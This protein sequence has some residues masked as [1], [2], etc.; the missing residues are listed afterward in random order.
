MVWTLADLRNRPSVRSPTEG[1]P[2]GISQVPAHQVSGT[3]PDFCSHITLLRLAGHALQP[4]SFPPTPTIHQHHLY[5][6]SCFT[7]QPQLMVTS[8]APRRETLVRQSWGP[9]Q[10][11][12]SSRMTSEKA[13][14]FSELG[15]PVYRVRPRA[16]SLRAVERI[17]R[18]RPVSRRLHRC[19]LLV[20]P[21]LCLH[22]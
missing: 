4:G 20:F 19:C 2:P 16:R 14:S 8:E 1:R 18:T 13:H 3:F 9:A 10:L 21:A 6:S 7:P 11:C 15:R 17:H 22:G 12:S 5:S